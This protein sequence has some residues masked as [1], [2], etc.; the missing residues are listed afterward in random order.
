MAPPNGLAMNFTDDHR[1]EKRPP[2][3][4]QVTRNQPPPLFIPGG[5]LEIL[6]G[7]ALRVSKSG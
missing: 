4:A 1:S 6:D 2:R 7:C 5:L 3:I